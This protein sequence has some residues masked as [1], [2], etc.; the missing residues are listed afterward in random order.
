MKNNGRFPI[1]L[2]ACLA[3]AT[4]AG[5]D[6]GPDKRSHFVG[7]VLLGGLGAKIGDYYVPDHRFLVGT[8]LGTLPGLCIEI[9]DSTNSS[10]FSGG[11]LLA[12]FLGAAIG[13]YLTDSFIL[14]PVVHTDKDKF[15]GLEL[16]TRF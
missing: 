9:A 1:F 13:A 11:D 12:D 4:A 14:K 7:G 5:D 15:V 2:A 10:G 6:F 3:A 16:G 8:A